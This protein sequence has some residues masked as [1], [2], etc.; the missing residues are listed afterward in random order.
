MNDCCM[1]Y[2]AQV[3]TSAGKWITLEISSKSLDEVNEAVQKYLLNHERTETR[4]IQRSIK[5][6]KTREKKVP[7]CC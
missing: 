2:L 1:Y 4:V 6:D 3:K 7:G 5:E